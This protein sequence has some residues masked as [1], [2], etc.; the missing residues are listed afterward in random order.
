M[1]KTWL[2]IKREYLTRVRNKTFI[3]STILTPLL[4]VGLITAVTVISVKNV[5]RETVA[6]VDKANIFR[7]SIDSTKA[8]TFSFVQGVDSTNYKVKGYS[9][10]LYAPT[11]STSKYRLISQKQLG[12]IAENNVEDKINES[13]ENR[14]LKSKYNIDTKELDAARKNVP[15]AELDQ[16]YY[17]GATIKKGNSELAYGIG[18][19]SGFLIYITLFIYGT[20]VMRGVMEEKTNRIAEVVI[21]S[22][23]PFQL[24]MGKII[25]IGAVGL[26]QLLLWIVLIIG[27]STAASAIFSHETLQ[28]ASDASQQ[29]NNGNV[30][31]AKGAAG[32]F[33]AMQETLG[34]ANWLLIIGCFIFYFLFGYLFY[35][36]L[37]AAVGSAVNEDPQDAQSLL[38]PITM[39]I[40]ISIVIMINAITNPAGSLATWSSMIPFFSPI[41]MMA[42]IPFGVPGT[43]PYWQLIVSML[44]LVLG[45]LGTTW[46]SAKIYRTGI[47]M[48]VKKAT[49]K[50]LWKWAWR[51]Y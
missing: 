49:W 40:I 17:E 45:F 26:T 12:M 31:M 24:M 9:A 41:V 13:M 39:P 37:F 1:S 46:I 25:G 15:H 50:E 4:F 48:Y 42:R 44:L 30:G 5:D 7:G 51:K 8:V 20:M 19:G 14:M 11:D 32:G 43:V 21:S 47:L 29:L 36:S 34:S 2:I 38:L 33:N 6:V 23:K 27:L 35:A 16:A 18:Y 10:I 22:V 28:Q 3:L